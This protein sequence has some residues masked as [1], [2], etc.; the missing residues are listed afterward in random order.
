MLILIIYNGVGRNSILQKRVGRSLLWECLMVGW[1]LNVLIALWTYKCWVGQEYWL[2]HCLLI[3]IEFGHNSV[4]GAVK[5]SFL[6]VAETCWWLCFLKCTKEKLSPCLFFS[7]GS[8]WYEH[9][10]LYMWVC[11]PCQDWCAMNVTSADDISVRVYTL[12]YVLTMLKRSNHFLL[13]QVRQ[14]WSVID[15]SFMHSFLVSFLLCCIF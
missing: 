11:I 12:S 5:V 3:Y 7:L 9:N 1:T 15:K 4:N 10:M 14:T 2:C 8:S 6:V 13:V